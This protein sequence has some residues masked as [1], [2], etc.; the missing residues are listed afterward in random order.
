MYDTGLL[1]GCRDVESNLTA[2]FHD[3]YDARKRK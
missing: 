1:V 3:G 2:P